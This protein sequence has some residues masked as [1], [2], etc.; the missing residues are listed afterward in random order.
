MSDRPSTEDV[1]R[2]HAQITGQRVA[3]GGLTRCPRCG[4]EGF[5]ISANG[6]GSHYAGCECQAELLDALYAGALAASSS[7]GSAPTPASRDEQ[8]DAIR[9][10]FTA[11]S[12]PKGAFPAIRR[13][14]K[15]GR[16]GDAYDLELADGS[17]LELGSAAD[18][19]NR[20]KFRAALFGQA[21]VVLILKP[22]DHANLAATIA[23]VAELADLPSGDQETAAWVS[24]YVEQNFVQRIDRSRAD[25][26]W[27]LLTTAG[28]PPPFLDT[29]G[30][31]YVQLDPLRA[32]LRRMDVERLTRRQ[33]AERLQ[34]SGFEDLTVAA[35]H[36]DQTRHRAY[37]ASPPGWEP[38]S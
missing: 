18:L 29:A 26:V 15:R 5:T 38:A 12:R 17:I 6:T 31:L 1:L 8:L 11:W 7:T 32:W 35:R 24:A 37:W 23:Q 25:Q 20:G 36:G 28:G 30:R 21:D 19:L 10:M 27:D 13:V 14:I 16:S 34:R 9:D 3:P 2:A 22:D 33:L 4:A